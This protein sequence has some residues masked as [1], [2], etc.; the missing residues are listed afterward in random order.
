[1][2]GTILTGV[3]A[4]LA[5]LAI[6]KTRDRRQ[7]NMGLI[8]IALS[9]ICK[10]IQPFTSSPNL[11]SAVDSLPWALVLAS[12]WFAGAAYVYWNRKQLTT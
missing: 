10:L 2:I 12:I 3:G 9:G 1:M 5:Y 4:A 6:Y 7:L 11:F 8:A